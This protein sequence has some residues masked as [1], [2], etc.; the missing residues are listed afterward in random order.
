MEQDPQ[1]LLQ[2]LH[3]AYQMA[4][5]LGQFKAGF[6]ARVSHELR[7]PLNSLIGVHQLILNDLCDSPEEER[8]FIRQAHESSLKLMQIIDQILDVAKVQSGTE[9][10]ALKP[11]SLSDALDEVYCLTYL[12][13]QN[14]NLQLHIEPLEPD[15]SV[16]ADP[17][18]L[19]QVLTSLVDT[20]LTLMQE[21]TVRV[22]AGPA[23]ETGMAHVWIEDER[24]ASFWAED[25]DLLQMTPKPDLL[26]SNT[27]SPG[28][29]LMLD[30][31]VLDSMGGQLEIL[32][33]PS[34]ASAE[35]PTPLTRIQCSIPLVRLDAA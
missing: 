27:L 23:S 18:R 28:M 13:A 19:Q 1:A 34:Q 29:R 11:T 4:I 22:T 31:M 24:P 35:V 9:Q 12:Q 10:L 32:S 7:S 6:L 33:S 16:L 26:P 21:G 20:P 17:K 5:E 30:K 25:L 14:R 3:L 2:Q 15:L 8:A